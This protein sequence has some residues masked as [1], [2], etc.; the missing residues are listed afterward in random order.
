MKRILIKYCLSLILTL[1]ICIPA[2]ANQKDIRKL[3][4]EIKYYDFTLQDVKKIR[5]ANCNQKY[6]EGVH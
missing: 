2:I 3:E 6:E 5:K 1:S 4:R